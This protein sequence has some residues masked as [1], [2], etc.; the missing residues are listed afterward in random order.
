LIVYDL[1]CDNSHGFE[2]W[3]GSS[4]EFERQLEAGDICCPLCSS[5]KIVRLPNASY[6][7]TRKSTARRKGGQAPGEI[8]ERSH[9]A[10]LADEMLA[11]VVDTILENT[12]DVG[13]AFPEEARKIHYQEA[14]ARHIRGTASAHEVDALREEGVD[15][16][17]LPVSLNRAGTTH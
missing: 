2:G 12:V 7:N 3:F 5:H 1:E 6:V 16:V 13:A 8:R 9:Y 17:A 14:P 11:K 10:N 4:E 15:V